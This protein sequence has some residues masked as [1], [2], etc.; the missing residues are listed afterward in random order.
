[1]SN[2]YF[3]HLSDQVNYINGLFHYR[4]RSDELRAIG[5]SEG[6]IKSIL[7]DPRNF[8][9]SQKRTKTRVKKRKA[10]RVITRTIINKLMEN[11]EK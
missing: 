1:M 9:R 10:N 2:N 5:L 4:E 8:N 11:K 6:E 3:K 7:G